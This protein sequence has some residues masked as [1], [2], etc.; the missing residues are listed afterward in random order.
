MA[1]IKYGSLAAVLLIVTILVLSTP[2]KESIQEWR[3]A[4]VPEKPVTVPEK[5]VVNETFSAWPTSGAASEIMPLQVR[6][7]SETPGAA[8]WRVDFGDGTFGILKYPLCMAGS[9]C[10]PAVIH[11]YTAAGTYVAKLRT[12]PLIT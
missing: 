10:H 1:Y 12:H 2:A 11:N 8:G 5:P 7:S 3:P 4:V 6:F 9:V